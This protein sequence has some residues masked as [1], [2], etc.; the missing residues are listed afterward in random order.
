MSY[1]PPQPPYYDPGQ[2]SQNPYADQPSPPPYIPP[3]SASPKERRP[4]PGLANL[5][6]LIGVIV[7]LGLSVIVDRAKWGFALTSIIGEG[8]LALVAIIF[9]LFGRY[10]F[11]ATFSLR[12]LDWK[13]VGLC[14]LAGLAGQFAVRFPAALN[15]WVM[16]IFGPFRTEDLIPDPKT[17][18]ERLLLLFV[19][20]AVAPICEETL[21]RGFVLAGYRQLSFGKSIFFVG[22]LFGLFHLYPF[23][24]SYTFLLGMAMAYLVLV[25]GSIWSSMSAHFGFNLI[26]GLSP[27]ILD[28]VKDVTR[29]SNRNL[30]EGD[31]QLDFAT[32]MATVPISL[33]ATAL[34]FLLLRSITK[35]IA[36][37]RPELE[38]G[39]FG[40]AR[41]IRTDRQPQPTATEGPFVGPDRRYRYGRYG[42]A[43][44]EFS[45][46]DT[47]SYTY[48]A[49][50]NPAVPW[51]TTPYPNPALPPSYSWDNPPAPRS[52][53]N[54]MVRLW[55][56]LSFIGIF[57]LYL[58]TTASEIALR[59]QEAN[60]PTPRKA[61][62][63]REMQNSEC[64]IQNVGGIAE[65][66]LYPPDCK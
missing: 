55:W 35:R 8:G 12:K 60:N 49:Y 7:F 9:C 66:S 65:N 2:P 19:V 30:I 22:L 48:P 11:K 63:V 34:F 26:G 43:R 44:T 58:L 62:M 6:F 50:N 4:N 13:I 47:A 57:G 23:R 39:Y 24:F 56:Q 42:Y 40:L 21:N 64:R 14:A 25:T 36:R 27:W 45:Q 29:D 33:A 53:L 41:A 15:Q 5:C 16:Q 32:V 46:P 20:A 1:N 38:L 37:Q 59:V 3:P 10:N 31:G 17:T 52:L 18:G 61:T 51:Q 54:S 28:W